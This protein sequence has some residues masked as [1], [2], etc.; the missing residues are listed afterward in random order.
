M[1]TVLSLGEC[2]TDGFIYVLSGLLKFNSPPP[3]PTMSIKDSMKNF[4]L[5]ET[6]VEVIVNSTN[7]MDFPGGQVVSNPSANTGET[8]LIPGPGRSHML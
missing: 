3:L 1:K 5:N 2:L 8:G 4:S 6:Y 7:F